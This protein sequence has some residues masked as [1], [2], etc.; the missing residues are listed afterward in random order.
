MNLR[1]NRGKLIKDG[2][3][4]YIYETPDNSN[5]LMKLYKEKDL[6]GNTI[7]TNELDSKLKYMVDNPPE[8]LVSK[9]IIAWPMKRLNDKHGNLAGFI[10]PRLDFDE[11][12]Q[13]IYSYRH[14]TLE[15]AEYQKFPS[16]ESRI[17]TAINLCSAID[18][19]QRKGYVFGDFNHHNIGVN[20][21][22]GQIYFMDCDSFHITDNTGVVYRTNVIMPGYLA[23]EIISHCR[24]ERAEGR[25]YSLDKVALPT[26]TKESDLFCLAVHIFK[27]LM[28]GVDPFK[29]VKNEAE[30]SDAAPFHGNEAIERNTYVFR[31][32]YKPSA[33]FC[34]PADTLPPEIQDLFNAAFIYGKPIS[35]QRPSAADWYIT[36]NRFLSSELVQCSNNKKHQYYKHLTECPYCIT[37][38]RHLT[39]QVKMSGI[40]PSNENAF[41]DENARIKSNKPGWEKIK[42]QF[43]SYT[44]NHKG[45]WFLLISAILCALIT[46]TSTYIYIPFSLIYLL[47]A[48]VLFVLFFKWKSKVTIKMKVIICLAIVVTSIL[49]F[50]FAAGLL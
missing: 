9:G 7:V 17:K 12:I 40:A 23:P 34:P 41:I 49:S 44:K 33:V 38:D 27:L 32:G 35:I 22:T 19:L 1:I 28:N 48:T 26:F 18:E 21:S 8:V 14:P 47:M 11:H 3:E 39:M 36:L 5:L 4:G 13:Q 50:A 15:A 20:Y 30:G 24:K 10:M 25:P 6:S 31:E 2:G 37:D 16:I 46:V 42:H 43:D 45:N 29:G